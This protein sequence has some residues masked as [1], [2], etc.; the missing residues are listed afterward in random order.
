MCLKVGPRGCQ[1]GNNWDEFDRA[2]VTTLYICHGQVINSIQ[3]AY[4]KSY[5]FKCKKILLDKHGGDGDKFESIDFAF[6]RRETIVGLSGHYSSAPDGAVTSLTITTEFADGKKRVYG[7]Y[8]K[9]EGTPFSFQIGFEKFGGFHGYSD[10]TC[11]RAI[12]VYVAPSADTYRGHSIPTLIYFDP[13]EAL[14]ELLY[15]DDY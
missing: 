12:G 11:L 14:D 15:P 9:E 2:I 10:E 7:P 3:I 6:N 13:E 1:E 4:I 8:G 5:H